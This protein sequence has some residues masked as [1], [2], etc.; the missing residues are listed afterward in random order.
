ML[1]K[2][3]GNNLKDISAW[4]CPTQRGPLQKIYEERYIIFYR[5]VTDIYWTHD[6]YSIKFARKIQL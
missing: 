3:I 2:D 6:W 5:S 1:V 4:T